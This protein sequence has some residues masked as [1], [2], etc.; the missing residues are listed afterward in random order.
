M[1]VTFTF[2]IR[3]FTRVASSSSLR[4]WLDKC[5]LQKH[6]WVYMQAAYSP[7][8]VP[9][10]FY[11]KH[12]S[13]CPSKPG[14]HRARRQGQHPQQQL[15]RQHRQ[16]AGLPAPLPRCCPA[17][18]LALHVAAAHATLVLPAP[19]WLRRAGRRERLRAGWPG[20]ERGFPGS[21]RPA[22]GPATHT[23]GGRQ[24]AEEEW[25]CRLC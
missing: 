6:W 21:S 23:C 17:L 18:V 16:R 7:P 5:T 24:H 9:C 13:E 12:R 20:A 2:Q 15:L 14:G 1:L 19:G 3:P 8:Q 11:L 10:P 4:L 22:A 25:H